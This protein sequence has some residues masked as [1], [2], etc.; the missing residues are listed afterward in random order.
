MSFYLVVHKCNGAM[1]I[2]CRHI[3]AINKSQFSILVENTLPLYA[4]RNSNG[5]S[6][7]IIK[8]AAVFSFLELH[9]L[10]LK[11]GVCLFVNTKM[12]KR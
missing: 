11:V 10:H 6:L 3:D 5:L 8:I 2:D 12:A 9:I 7:R 1:E 4:P